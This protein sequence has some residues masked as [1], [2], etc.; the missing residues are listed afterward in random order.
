MNNMVITDDNELVTSY[1]LTGWKK[2]VSERRVDI[3]LVTTTG[4]VVYSISTDIREPN[5]DRIIDFLTNEINATLV[6]NKTLLISEYLQRDYISV[7]D[8][9]SR[10]FSAQKL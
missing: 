10:Q 9:Y 6:G 1:T 5:L 4:N 3:T 8:D 7:G 2:E